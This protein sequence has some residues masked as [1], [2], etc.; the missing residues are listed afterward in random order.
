MKLKFTLITTLFILLN[1]FTLRSQVAYSDLKK[2]QENRSHNDIKNIKYRGEEK[3]LIEDFESWPPEGFTFYELKDPAGWETYTEKPASGTASAY[4]NS[5]KVTTDIE[6]WM[7]TRQITVPDKGI[8]SFKEK[9]YYHFDMKHHGVHISTSGNDPKVDQFEQVYF[10][11]ENAGKWKETEIDLSA[12]SGQKVYIGFKYTGNNAARWYIDDISMI[13]PAFDDIEILEFARKGFTFN[14]KDAVISVKLLNAGRND[15]E[16]INVKLV[17]G[18][19]NLSQEVSIAS[20]ETKDIEFKYTPVYGT[21]N[22]N[23]DVELETDELPENN[24]AELSFKS[25]L[26]AN[27][28]YGYS[29]T[30]TKLNGHVPMS[31]VVYDKENPQVIQSETSVDSDEAVSMIYLDGFLYYMTIDGKSPKNFIKYNIETGERELLNDPTVRILNMAYNPVDK[32]V[33]GYAMNAEAENTTIDFYTIDL[34]TGDISKLK[35]VENAPK[36]LTFSIDNNGTGY[37]IDLNEAKLYSVSLDDFAFN[38]IGSTGLQISYAQTSAFDFDTKTLYW[39]PSYAKPDGTFP[40]GLF[41]VNIS[42]GSV[43]HI[44]DFI[45]E[46]QIAGLSIP[47]RIE[48]ALVNLIPQ[49]FNSSDLGEWKT[50]KTGD[51]ASAGW[52]INN[53]Y[54]KEGASCIAHESDDEFDDEY[55]IDYVISPKFLVPENAYLQYWERNDFMEYNYIE[56]GIYISEGSDDPEKGE[57]VLITEFKDEHRKWIKRKVSLEKYAGKEVHI[58]FVYKGD[59]GPIWMIDDVFVGTKE[60]NELVA[61]SIESK[62]IVLEGSVINPRGIV[63]NIG[64]TDAEGGIA[65][66]IIGNYREVKPLYTV[67]ENEEIVEFSPY[68]VKSGDS[69]II[70]NIYKDGETDYS[71]NS[72]SKKITITDPP[73]EKAYAYSLYETENLAFGPISY[74]IFNP[75]EFKSLIHNTNEDCISYAGAMIHKLWFS[76]IIKLVKEDP[77]SDNITE[78]NH[79]WSL[80]DTET[81]KLIQ[82]GKNSVV[83]KEMSYDYSTNTLYGIEKVQESLFVLPFSRLHIID[84]KTGE[85]TV[86]ADAP[87]DIPNVLAFAI[88]LDGSAYAICDNRKF[89][90]V[91]LKDFT[92][93]LIGKTG[94]DDVKYDQSMAFDH[95]DPNEPLYWNMA[96]YDLGKIYRVDIETGK[97]GLINDIPGNGELTCLD[98]PYGKAKHYISFLLKDENGEL[99]KD[100]SVTVDNIKKKTNVDG[101]ASFA[102]IERDQKVDYNIHVPSKDL[103]IKDNVVVRENM[104]H[105][106]TCTGILDVEQL[107]IAIYPNPSNGKINI[108]EVND[109]ILKVVDLN[110][111]EVFSQTLSLGQKSVDL[112]EL[113]NGLYLL[114]FYSNDKIYSAKILLHK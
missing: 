86:V 10:S 17:D 32:K 26:I 110:G 58:A 57:F 29:R 43:E 97:A 22:V 60:E 102:L 44:K 54:A 49:G 18:D 9:N 2:A 38:E 107:M 31:L 69:E 28:V 1:C 103:T 108:N 83:F 96:N 5:L 35:S 37:C 45:S 109:G 79:S 77:E 78:I 98:F 8:L 92:F 68:T 111:K 16:A 73:K 112:T 91:N 40:A 94:L 23:V 64:S 30:S 99:I 71:N 21:H 74:N 80:L 50:V 81:G 53:D 63:E 14:G 90:S 25:L 15:Q 20:G 46:E 85:S 42:D 33:Y 93:T 114:K 72:I 11:E 19:I 4:H 27:P 100:A 95:N 61:H 13:T 59:Q 65:E 34:A 56:N 6:D 76:N 41:K 51:E 12:Y 67:A 105:E 7:V 106:I 55:T 36:I 101:I 47:F 84:P 104:I 39:I 82:L 62:D 66:L 87:E 48:P 75:I 88:K 89:Y 113:K 52:I 3:T 70:F 24:K